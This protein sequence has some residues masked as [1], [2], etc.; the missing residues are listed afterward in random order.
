MA[1]KTHRLCF[2]L[3]AGDVFAAASSGSA[4]IYGEQEKVV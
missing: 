4:V 3:R 2:G 1:A